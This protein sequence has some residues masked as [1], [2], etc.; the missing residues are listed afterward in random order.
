MALV[1]SLTAKAAFGGRRRS[2]QTKSAKVPLL[3]VDLTLLFQEVAAAERSTGSFL[4]QRMSLE[5]WIDVSRL[6]RAPSG[7]MNNRL[8]LFWHRSANIRQGLLSL[9]TAIRV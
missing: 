9:D 5:Q 4:R 8:L 3:F 1:A 7:S 2:F 6:V